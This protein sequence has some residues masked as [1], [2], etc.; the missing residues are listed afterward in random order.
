[1]A[2]D[3]R[4]FIG[5]GLTD[6]VADKLGCTI[7]A[8][9]PFQRNSF[10][11]PAGRTITNH[12]IPSHP[13]HFGVHL[14]LGVSRLDVFRTHIHCAGFAQEYPQGS[15]NTMGWNNPRNLSW[16]PALFLR[17]LAPRQTER[18]RLLR[19]LA[20]RGFPPRPFVQEVF[21]RVAP[22]LLVVGSAGTQWLDHFVL[23]EAARRKIPSFCVTMSWDNMYSRGPMWFRPDM[24]GVWSNLMRD[25]AMRVHDFPHDYIRII[26]AMQFA[27]YQEQVTD[28]EVREV[29]QSLG[30]APGEEYLAYV[31]GS[32][33]ATYDC[34]DIHELIKTLRG[35]NF[36]NLKVV[37][38]PHP[39]GDKTTYQQLVKHGVILDTPPDLRTGDS[40]LE[41]MDHAGARHMAALLAASRFV[42]S[43]W[44]TTALLEACILDRPTLQLRW[45]DAIPH[46]VSSEVLMV[47][48]FQNYLHM[49]DFDQTQARVFSDSPSDLIQKMNSL[50]END[51]E[52]SK[53]RRLAM[54]TICHTPLGDCGR[55]F[56]SGCED[57]L[58]LPRQ[59][60]G[61]GQ[62]N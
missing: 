7:D 42:V 8:I 15:L 55:R 11:S 13:Q 29:R 20:R 49:R 31:C 23:E 24:L 52:F 14:P 56:A 44:G 1:M 5:T 34:E 21:D 46:G 41:R 60:I 6:A 53:R 61:H 62:L 3:I 35:S 36:R 33:T 39:Q 37:V 28:L 45:M 19:K 40:A 22:N 50:E 57:A 47:R 30:L 9:S 17:F 26:G 32:R 2:F 10:S 48:K 27:F 54:E 43:S 18:R 12:T 25:Q 59:A 16:W 4:N 58:S 38:R 51:A